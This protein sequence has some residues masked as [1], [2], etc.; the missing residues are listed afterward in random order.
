MSGL[1][2]EL[3]TA[4][5]AADSDFTSAFGYSQSTVAFGAGIISVVLVSEL[6][7]F[8]LYEGSPG[9]RHLEKSGIFLNSCVVVSGKSSE[10]RYAVGNETYQPCKGSSVKEK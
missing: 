7:D 5:G 6:A 1:F 10:N 9:R 4:V 8:F 2:R 3:L